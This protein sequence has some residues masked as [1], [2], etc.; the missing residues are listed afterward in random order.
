M[1]YKNV[2]LKQ[3]QRIIVATIYLILV[4]VCVS[5]LG[6]NIKELLI[7]ATDESIWFYSGILLI[8]M[9][10]YVTEPFFSTPADCLS[11]SVATMLAMLSI[12]NKPGFALY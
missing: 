10:Q 8:I 5:L 3:P 11:N 7:G 9:G 4:F 2:K 6:G 12:Q 1:L